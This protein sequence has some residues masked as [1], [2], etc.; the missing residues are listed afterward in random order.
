[1]VP[2]FLAEALCMVL[3]VV[4]VGEAV[5]ASS[6]VSSA[7]VLQN[8]APL[9]SSSVQLVAA[10]L[11]APWFLRRLFS[12]TLYPAGLSHFPSCRGVFTP[13]NNA[14]LAERFLVVLLRI[15]S[16]CVRSSPSV[17]ESGDCAPFVCEA[18]C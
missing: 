10:S 18:P 14:V 9:L 4:V 6:E 13:V 2:A 1:M 16:A 3:P 11:S 15:S 7:L 17:D 5:L 8:V 12:G